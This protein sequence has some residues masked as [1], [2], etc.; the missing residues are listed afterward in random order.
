MSDVMQRDPVLIPRKPGVFMLVN[1]KRRLAYVAYSSDLQKRSHSLAHMLQNPKTHWSL[2][3][4]PKHPAGE[5]E[6]MVMA[7]DVEPQRAPRYIGAAE[8]SA[9]NKNYRIVE[10]S[11]SAVPM[12]WYG[13]E[14][15]T[16]ADAIAK[17]R[18]RVKYITVWRR[19][20][21]GWTTEQA[22]GLAP[23]PIRW[24]PDQTTERRKRAAKK[25]TH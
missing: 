19:L 9:R 7:E 4:L 5:F 13:G 15:L 21:R 23:P 25:R 12:V 1:R 2:K 20:D 24:D 17:A 14:Y 16:L 10:G 3:D 18:C 22:L 6:F 11:R 8:R